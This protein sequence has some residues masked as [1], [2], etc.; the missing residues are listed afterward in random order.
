MKINECNYNN[1]KLA[2]TARWDKIAK[3][4]GNVDN[5]V[6]KLSPTYNHKIVD[7]I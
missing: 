5:A 1:I 3:Y 4:F 2:G 6:K 7:I